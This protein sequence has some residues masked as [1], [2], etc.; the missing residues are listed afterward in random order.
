MK[1]HG[2]RPVVAGYLA[3]P[4]H[5]DPDAAERVVTAW[6]VSCAAFA[7]REGY[8]LG[9]VF[10]DVRGRDEC[11]IYG[12]AEYLRRDGVVAVV[13]PDVGHLTQARCLSGADLRAVRRFLRSAVLTVGSRT[14]GARLGH[15]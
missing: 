6:R 7:R 1:A 3:V 2:V 14:E 5:A 13:V 4:G 8:A 15:R 9:A 12:L 11:G 10:S